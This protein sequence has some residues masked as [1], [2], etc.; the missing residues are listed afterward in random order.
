MPAFRL[1]P[2][3]ILRRKDPENDVV[4][5]ISTESLH[6]DL[7]ATPPRRRRLTLRLPRWRSEKKEDTPEDTPHSPFLDID[8]DPSLGDASPSK[9]LCSVSGTSPACKVSILGIFRL[10][11][12]KES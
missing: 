2:R 4:I 5:R 7:S 3:G 6:S 12:L 9:T 11:V 10:F 1:F 8:H